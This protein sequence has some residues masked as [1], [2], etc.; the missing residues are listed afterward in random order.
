MRPVRLVRPADLR[1]ARSNPDDDHDDHATTVSAPTRAAH[2]G[3]MTEQ[4]FTYEFEALYADELRA[5]RDMSDEEIRRTY[6]RDPGPQIIDRARAL[7]D[8]TRRRWERDAIERAI[9]GVLNRAEHAAHREF[10]DFDNSDA[11]TTVPVGS[12]E[13]AV[14]TV[15]VRDLVAT[16]TLT[17]PKQNDPDA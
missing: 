5:K 2:L 16:A 13:G 1:N 17:L 14:L 6:V 8:V 12:L 15:T 9:A 4:Q 10:P 11:T 3:P 7:N